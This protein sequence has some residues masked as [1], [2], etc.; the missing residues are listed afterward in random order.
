MN[1]EESLNQVI[2]LTEKM[3][4]SAVLDDWDKV[5]DI[6]VQRSEALNELKKT[7][8][9]SSLPKDDIA[10]RLRELIDMNNRLTHLGETKKAEYA[11]QFS[12]GKKGA[13][14]FNAYT[15]Y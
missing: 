5:I 7:Q 15:G 11:S 3:V 4:A 2:I 12:S 13:R 8:F 9:K 14:A 6:E 10:F 1:Y